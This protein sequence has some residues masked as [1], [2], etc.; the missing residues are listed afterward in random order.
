MSVKVIP[1]GSAIKGRFGTG[2]KAGGIG[3]LAVGLGARMFGPLG[4]FMGAVLGGAMLTGDD[5][6][7]VTIN[8]VMDAIAAMLLTT[9]GGG[10]GDSI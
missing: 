5:G 9:G 7:I 8:G 4:A 3:G 6:K 2:L 1:S 10:G